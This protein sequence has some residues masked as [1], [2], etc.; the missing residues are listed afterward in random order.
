MKQQFEG[1]IFD[2]DGTLTST[3]ELIFASFNHI[4]KKYLKKTF[5]D[6]EIHSMKG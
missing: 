2:I 1:F 3:N 4:A 6:E 5:T